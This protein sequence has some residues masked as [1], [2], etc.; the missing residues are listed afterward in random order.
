MVRVEVREP[1]FGN[2]IEAA[3]DKGTKGGVVLFILDENDPPVIW[4]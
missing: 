2:S 3:T 4:V 1:V